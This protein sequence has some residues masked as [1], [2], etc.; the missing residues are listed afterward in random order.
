MR[1]AL[2]LGVLL[3][4]VFISGAR[5]TD[6]ELAGHGGDTQTNPPADRLEWLFWGDLTPEMGL[7]C[8]NTSGTS[9]GPND[10][11]VGVT[12]DLT[13]PI[14]I[15]QHYYNIF[16]QVSPNITDLDFVVWRGGSELPGPER[17]RASLAPNWGAGDHT[18]LIPNVFV[19]SQHFFFGQN[20][21]QTNVGMRWGLDTSSGSWGASLIRA[22]TCGASAFT[23]V[24]NLGF[25][26]SWVLAVSH[27]IPVPVDLQSWGAVKASFR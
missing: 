24:D 11:A 6:V 13:P 10:V 2:W 1:I 23:L 22:P 26:G 9:G 19:T 20:Q 25:P 14:Q 17:G 4:C 15:T 16:T 7:G 18:V 5:A 27:G 12:A 21:P 8:S 3:G